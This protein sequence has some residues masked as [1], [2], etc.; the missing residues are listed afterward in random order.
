[1]G[2]RRTDLLALR[3]DGLSAGEDYGA[4]HEEAG[5]G[6]PKSAGAA[7]PNFLL[8]PRLHAIVTACW[9]HAFFCR[10]PFQM[11]PQVY[12]GKHIRRYQIDVC[13]GCYEGNWDGWAPRFEAQLIPRLKTTGLPIPDRNDKGWLPRD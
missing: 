8:C 9:F 5:G 11:G 13:D 10:R 2:C 7:R 12:Q 6:A 3:Y 1:V 4:R